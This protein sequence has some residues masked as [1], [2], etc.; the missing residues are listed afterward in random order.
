MLGVDDRQRL[1]LSLDLDEVP[2]GRDPMCTR[3]R[4][5]AISEVLCGALQV[6]R[7]TQALLG[8]ARVAKRSI[9]A[10]INGSSGGTLTAHALR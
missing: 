9:R 3:P 5:I 8:E 4:Y 7:C 1:Q 6:L 10:W 2:D